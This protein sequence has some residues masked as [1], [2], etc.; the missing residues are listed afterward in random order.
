MR[1]DRRKANELREVT[2]EREFVKYAQGSTLISLGDTEVI[3]AAMVEEGVPGFLRGGGQGWL[4]AEY[5][6]L[7]Y[8]SPNRLPRE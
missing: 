3:C 5:T 2:I 4:T 1:K 7:P 8:A 6:L